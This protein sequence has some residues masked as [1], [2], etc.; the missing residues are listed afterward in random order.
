[1]SSYSNATT[2]SKISQGIA[3]VL[4]DNT[5]NWPGVCPVIAGIPSTFELSSTRRLVPHVLIFPRLNRVIVVTG[6]IHLSTAPP[7]SFLSMA[8]M[9]SW[10][11][12]NWLDGLFGYEFK[13]TS[14]PD[15]AS[16]EERPITSKISNASTSFISTSVVTCSC[17]GMTSS[18]ATSA[19][20]A[21]SSHPNLTRC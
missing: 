9:G 11:I 19:N 13:S 16:T 14:G 2:L 6:L 3:N 17:S 18:M 20:K 12:P 10:L 15:S 1:M 8:L 7:H 5:R 21:R 4:S